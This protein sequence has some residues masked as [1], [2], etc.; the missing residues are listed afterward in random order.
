MADTKLSAITENTSP[1]LEDLLYSVDDPGGTPVEKRVTIENINKGLVLLEEVT[2]SSGV[3]SIDL[4]NWYSADYDEYQIEVL[5]LIPATNTDQLYMRVST[6]GGISYDS[7]ANYGSGSFYLRDGS[8]DYDLGDNSGANEIKLTYGLSNIVANGGVNGTFKM[9]NPGSTIH[10]K[11]INFTL[12]AIHST[13]SYLY[14]MWGTG[15]YYSTT[16]VNAFQFL[17]STGNITGTVRVYGV[18][19]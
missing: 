7:G 2:E 8:S 14:N 1:A 6:N 19:K 4:E 13:S 5:N 18:R 12:S 3:A 9:Y 11:A 16:A 15:R 17:M 10:Y